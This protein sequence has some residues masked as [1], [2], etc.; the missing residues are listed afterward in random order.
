MSN[1]F[2]ILVKRC[3]RAV[4]QSTVPL[5]QTYETNRKQTFERLGVNFV[6]DVGA[7]RG[8]YATALRRSGY[9]GQIV[10]IEPLPDAFDALRQA[11]S[12]DPNWAGHNVAAGERPGRAKLNVS[13]DS[14]CSSLLAPSPNLLDTISTART[15]GVLDIEVVA[16]DDIWRNLGNVAA[17][18]ALKLDVQGFEREA[19]AGA[20][21]FL[22]GAVALE[23]ELALQPSYEGAYTLERALPSLLAL[24]FSVVSVGRGYS[25]PKTGKLIDLDVL[26]ERL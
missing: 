11:F 13:S 23:I 21:Q 1:P 17:R 20:Q 8:Q 16:L 7:N 25:D 24:G 18:P 9:T 12:R 3:L 19:L 4:G 22:R 26:L 2:A 5:S 6:F 14:V 15:I 10:S